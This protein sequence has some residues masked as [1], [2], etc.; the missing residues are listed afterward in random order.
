VTGTERLLAYLTELAFSPHGHDSYAIG[1][2]LSGD[3]EIQVSRQAK[4]SPSWPQLPASTLR[5]SKAGED[6]RAADAVQSRRHERCASRPIRAGKWGIAAAKA[7]ALMLAQSMIKRAAPN[8][9][10]GKLL[11]GV[12]PEAYSAARTRNWFHG[13][14]VTPVSPATAKELHP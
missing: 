8:L 7:I 9:G 1:V 12:K 14:L 5:T 10:G 3:P 11:A 6:R 2:A 13:G 4:I